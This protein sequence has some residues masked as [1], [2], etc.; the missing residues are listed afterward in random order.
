GR[1]AGVDGGSRGTDRNIALIHVLENN[2][3][4]LL[5]TDVTTATEVT[6]LVLC[7]SGRSL[8]RYFSLTKRMCMGEAVSPFSASTGALLTALVWRPATGRNGSWRRWR[9][10]GRLQP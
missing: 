7:R 6:L 9:R 4:V 10:R 5:G 2:V 3:E 8:L 1:I